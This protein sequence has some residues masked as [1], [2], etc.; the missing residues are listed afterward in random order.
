MKTKF[1]KTA[2]K[3]VAWYWVKYK[4]KNGLTVCPAQVFWMGKSRAER[5]AS[6]IEEK[7]AR[8]MYWTCVTARNDWFAEESQQDL[9]FGPMIPMPKGSYS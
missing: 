8:R 7:E 3:T 4:G 2:P 9:K 1:K 5:E 6:G